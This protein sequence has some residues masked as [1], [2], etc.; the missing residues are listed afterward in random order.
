MRYEGRE[1]E[2]RGEMLKAGIE[3]RDYV[4]R[5]SECARVQMC[6]FVCVCV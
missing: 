2:H 4:V 3:E 6:I 5:M 1:G